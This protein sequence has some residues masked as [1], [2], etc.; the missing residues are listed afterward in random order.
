MKK[1]VLAL[2]SAMA[3]V[4]G[5]TVQEH[6]GALFEAAMRKDAAAVRAA[7]DAGADVNARNPIGQ[8]P[9]MMAAGRIGGDAV[10]KVLLERGADPNLKDKSPS[11][12]PFGIFS[13]QTNAMIEASRVADGRSL[14]MLFEAGADVDLTNEHGGTA[15]FYA[16][17]SGNRENARLLMDQKA[18][19]NARLDDGVTPLIIAVQ[20]DDRELAAE[21][22]ARGADVKAADRNGNTPLLWAA[23]TERADTELVQ[24]LM[25][26]GAT[27]ADRNKQGETA[28]DWAKRRGNTGVVKMLTGAMAADLK[29]DTFR[30]AATKGLPVLQASSVQFFKVSG[31]V[32]CHNQSLPAM[33]VKAARERGIAVNEETAVKAKKITDANFKPI[34]PVVSVAPHVMPEPGLSLSYL[35]LGV[36]AEDPESALI[37]P[38]AAG[39]AQAQRE[40]GAWPGMAVRPP[41][42]EGDI[43]PTSLAVVALKAAN[44]KEEAA[45]RRGVEWLRHAQPGTTADKAMRAWALGVGGAPAADVKA[46][47]NALMMEQ[48]A[49]GGW[50]GLDG[51]GESD[52]YTTGL[53]LVALYEAKAIDVTADVYRRG[54][55]Y[56]VST[57]KADG[58]WMVKTRAF[59]LQPYKE[60]GFPYGKDQ[61]ISAAGTSFAVMA[62][63]N[64]VS[65]ATNAE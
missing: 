43:I 63:T 9:L 47:A 55:A 31:C 10:V 13:G 8:T 58:T 12:V 64:A 28:L 25:K 41:M 48:R 60:S 20:R 5:A 49:D 42:S 2:F 51:L 65:P 23:Y 17:V 54:L 33:A 24:K 29:E 15:L 61:W 19:V 6:N 3:M 44:W 7:L 40:D 39:I 11:I 57:Q 37:E 26:A 34:L 21:L 18:N 16:I 1:T 36:I 35:L 32:S 30:A 62:L 4:Q 14:R 27:T 45:I 38:M 22:I 46:A 50:V 59:P 52:A 53:A 56:L